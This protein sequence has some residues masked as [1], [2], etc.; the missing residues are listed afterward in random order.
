MAIKIGTVYSLAN[1][2]NETITPDDRQEILETIG[3]VVVQDFGHITNGDKLVWQG[4]EFWSTDFQTII[5]YWD[6]RDL[7]E[8]I[9]QTGTSFYARVVVRSYNR[10]YKFES[11]AISATI[12]L[13]K[14]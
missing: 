8:I 14:I 3:G 5:G 4:L 10:I 2:K 9:D 11:K 6:S 1:P 12:E 13:W 7:V